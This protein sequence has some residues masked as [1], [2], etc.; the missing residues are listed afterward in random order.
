MANLSKS[1]SAYL[2]LAAFVIFGLR[3]KTIKKKGISK[4]PAFNSL[5]VKCL[6]LNMLSPPNCYSPP[7][8]PNESS[9]SWV[10]TTFILIRLFPQTNRASP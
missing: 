1:K 7:P 6:K 2:K 9:S 4:I 3:K 5:L 8:V 10:S